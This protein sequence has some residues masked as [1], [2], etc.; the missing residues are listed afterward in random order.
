MRQCR[1]G[2][3]SGTSA[4]AKSSMNVPTAK[5]PM[6]H[7]DPQTDYE[8]MLQRMDL[9]CSVFGCWRPIR[10]Y[11]GSLAGAK[12]ASAKITLEIGQY[13]DGSKHNE[14]ADPFFLS[15]PPDF[16]LDPERL[17]LDTWPLHQHPETTA[18][19]RAK[20]SLSD[21]RHDPGFGTR[22]LRDTSVLQLADGRYNSGV[23]S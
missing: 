21:E 6:L 9:D 14:P 23:G 18:P 4:Y 20:V 8:R 12:W 5:T 17:L 22:A 1:A 13:G 3:K 2:E 16:T 7:E 19:S 15:W 10:A 11:A